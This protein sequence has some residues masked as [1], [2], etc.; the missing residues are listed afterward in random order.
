MSLRG[1]TDV[2]EIEV[3][4]V[5]Q[6]LR[7]V[8]DVRHGESVGELGGTGGVEVGDGDQPGTFGE[9][10]EGFGMSVGDTA[11]ADDGH[12][13]RRPGAGHGCFLSLG[14]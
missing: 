6:S 7:V 11:G 3:F 5:Q 8:E 9:F 2:Y 10:G 1:R 4:A 14:S 13:V 12:A